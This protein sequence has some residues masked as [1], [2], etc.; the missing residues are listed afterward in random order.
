MSK[1]SYQ[2]EPS[3]QEYSNNEAENIEIKR[4]HD[5][6]YRLRQ[7]KQK[8]EIQFE[9]AMQIRSSIESIHLENQK[10]KQSLRESEQKVED[11][12]KICVFLIN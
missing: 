9:S 12:Q 3:S 5:E 6:N 4:L 11:Y 10:L 8:L 7:E 2:D 1:G